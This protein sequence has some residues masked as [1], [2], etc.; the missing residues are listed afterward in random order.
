MNKDR[1]VYVISGPTAVGKSN[2]AIELAKMVNGEIVN[3]DSVQVYKGLN[4]GSAKP[5][6][7]ELNEIPHHLYDLVDPDY[8]MTV[9]I[10]QKLAYATLDNIIARGKVPIVVGGTGLYMNSILFD[11]DFGGAGDDGCRR[12]ELEALAEKMGNDYMHS[13]LSAVDPEAAERIHF[14][15]SRKVIRAIEAFELG[16]GIKDLKEC[17]LNENYNFKFFAIT[18]KR[19]ILYERI[20]HRVLQMLKSGLEKEIR[21]LV[22][23]GYSVET[24][25]MTKAIGYKEMLPYIAGACTLKDAA[26]EIQ[27]NSRHY[28]KRQITWLK[29]YDFV[30][31]IETSPEEPEKSAVLRILAYK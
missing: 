30:N 4:I 28:A 24:P 25:I 17:P 14:N 13:Y 22:D 27:K 1:T 21:D 8:N 2:I 9:A 23:R 3:C 16:D 10:Y 15:N 11:M 26:T 18:M 5:S 7:K 20:N 29:R 19:E 31:W 12:T 6:T